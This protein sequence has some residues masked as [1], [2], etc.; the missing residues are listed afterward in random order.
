M[1][2][3]SHTYHARKHASQTPHVEAIVIVL[4]IYE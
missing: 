4:Q 3:H 2:V 1:C